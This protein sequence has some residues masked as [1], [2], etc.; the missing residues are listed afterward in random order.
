[1][2]SDTPRGL[3]ALRL[4]VTVVLAAV[5]AVSVLTYQP[6][7]DRAEQI[8]QLIK[9]PVC[10]GESIADSGTQLADDMMSLVRQ[11]IDEGASDDEIID[12]ILA[13]YSGAVLLDPG[14]RPSTIALWLIPGAI[15][16]GGLG[17]VASRRRRQDPIEE[18][19]M[20]RQ[21][22][23][24]LSD[25]EGV[26][27]QREMGEIDDETAER[28]TALYETELAVTE[29]AHP[30][31]SDVGPESP[32]GW[33]KRA[34]VGTTLLVGV[35]A[36]VLVGAFVFLGDP[37]GTGSGVVDD[38]VDLGSVSNDTMESVIAA[39][40]DDP[41]IDGMRLAL[42]E[43]YFEESGY[44]DAFPHYMAVAESDSADP[45]QVATALTRLGWMT[46]DGSGEVETAMQLLDRALEVTPG[47]P[48][49]LYLKGQI[50]WCGAD[51]PQQAAGIFSDVLEKPDLDPAVR[52]AVE[53]DLQAVREGR[54]CPT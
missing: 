35:F 54:S 12:Q 32:G 6:D 3:S 16:I 9:C 4:G 34:I 48:L 14:V 25:L 20:T 24:I 40:L 15:L 26:A 19:D 33:S 39:N 17:L 13:S 43:R 23:A 51:R 45:T 49:P 22:E 21:R 30:T 37:E 38:Q 53:E 27:A 47:A 5:I 2:S 8:G 10:S 1:M 42:A 28:L 11:R 7:V 44:S 31:P 46:Y 18:E 41:N 29:V 36:A 50:T 52:S